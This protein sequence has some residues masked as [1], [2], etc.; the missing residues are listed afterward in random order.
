MAFDATKTRSRHGSLLSW[1]VGVQAS[2]TSESSVCQLLAKDRAL[3]R[4]HGNLLFYSKEEGL[5]VDFK[6]LGYGPSGGTTHVTRLDVKLHALRNCSYLIC[7]FLWS[8]RVFFCFV[9]LVLESMSAYELNEWGYRHCCGGSVHNTA[10]LFAQA[11][12]RHISVRVERVGLLRLLRWIGSQHRLF[13]VICRDARC[14]ASANISIP[15]CK[16]NNVKM[17]ICLYGTVSVGSKQ[18]SNQFGMQ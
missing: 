4:S 10:R 2:M 17:S 6:S 14:E 15:K 12:H 5:T 18:P 16:A 7:Y 13:T 9:F 3:Y 11:L 1:L 8:E